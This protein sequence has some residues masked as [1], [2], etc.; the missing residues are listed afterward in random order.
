MKSSALAKR[1]AGSFSSD[2]RI[3]A[4]SAGGIAGLTAL[5]AGGCSPT[6]FMAMATALSPSK[7]SRPVAIS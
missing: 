1:R 2:L 7:G 4:S 3:T 5:G 6:C